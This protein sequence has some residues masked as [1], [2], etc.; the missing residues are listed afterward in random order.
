[1]NSIYLA[2]YSTKKIKENGENK[3]KI[4]KTIIKLIANIKDNDISERMVEYYSE[5]KDQQIL[6]ALQK[7][8]NVSFEDKLRPFYIGV[9]AEDNLSDL[10]KLKN[11]IDEK[12][13]LLE[14]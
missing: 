4:I 7:E 13:K 10:V 6:E 5:T 2:N 11:L 12:V 8:V 14:K 3:I 1:M 9:S